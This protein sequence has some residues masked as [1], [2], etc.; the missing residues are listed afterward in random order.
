MTAISAAEHAERERIIA[1]AIHSGEMEGLHVTEATK[2][3][4]DKYIDG[5]STSTSSRPRPAHGTGSADFGD[6]HVDPDTGILENLLGLRTSASLDAAE[7]DLVAIPRAEL[8]RSWPKPTGDLTELRAELTAEA[9][10]KGL[11]RATFIARL[12]KHYDQLNYVRPFR[13]GNGRTQ[14][15]FWDRIARWYLDWIVAPR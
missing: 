6:P 12:A 1:A 7:A 15:T 4:T 9:Y 3:D 14:R 13:E 5:D 11:D 8:E 2:A 10:L